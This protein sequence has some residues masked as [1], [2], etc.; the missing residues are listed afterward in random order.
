[1][2]GRAVRRRTMVVCRG[3][4][5]VAHSADNQLADVGPRQ[6][7]VVVVDQGDRQSTL[8]ALLQLERP[9]V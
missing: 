5:R 2:M 9:G 6:V 7:R 4:G 1:M 3:R 8:N